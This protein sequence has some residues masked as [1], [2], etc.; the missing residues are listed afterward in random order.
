MCCSTLSGK[1][2][3]RSIQIQ[4]LINIPTLEVI[5]F[6]ILERVVNDNHGKYHSIEMYVIEHHDQIKGLQVK[7]PQH[8]DVHH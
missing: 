1:F 4:K 7:I 6:P 2:C 8:K 5:T 3:E